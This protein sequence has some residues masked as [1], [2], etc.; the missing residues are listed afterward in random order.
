MAF[1]CGA[2][3]SKI[4]MNRTVVKLFHRKAFPSTVNGI[5]SPFNKLSSYILIWAIFIPDFHRTYFEKNRFYA[6]DTLKKYLY[7]LLSQ[8]LFSSGNNRNLMKYK[9]SLSIIIYEVN[10]GKVIGV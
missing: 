8:E 4:T 10:K 7:A 6:I 3:S 9:K 1:L 2:N 5:S